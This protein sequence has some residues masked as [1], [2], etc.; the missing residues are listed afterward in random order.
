MGP[1]PIVAL[2][3]Y[4][5]PS[6]SGARGTVARV[7]TIESVDRA[8]SAPTSAC[9]PTHWQRTGEGATFRSM[10]LR[11][12]TCLAQ[13]R[14]PTSSIRRRSW[15][16]WRTTAT[17]PDGARRLAGQDPGQG[18]TEPL[19]IRIKRMRPLLLPA[20]Q[21]SCGARCLGTPLGSHIPSDGTTK[22]THPGYL[23][24]DQRPGAAAANRATQ[25]CHSLSKSLMVVGSP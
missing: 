19:A 12:H 15:W 22:T 25:R 9:P 7:K 21:C 14:S 11:S 13:T 10:L 5:T 18:S 20:C 6:S 17:R 16:R 23:P 24:A 3:T 4:R 8:G 2:A 1:D